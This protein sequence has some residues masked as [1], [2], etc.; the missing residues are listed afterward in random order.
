MNQECTPGFDCQRLKINVLV[1]DTLTATHHFFGNLIY[2]V[3]FDV[4]NGDKIEKYE[5]QNTDYSLEIVYSPYTP[6]HIFQFYHCFQH[7]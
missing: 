1:G 4:E 7:L 2:K 5:W 6:V 3:P